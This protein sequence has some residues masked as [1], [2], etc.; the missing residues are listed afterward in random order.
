M[1][2]E[3]PLRDLD[4]I[5]LEDNVELPRGPRCTQALSLTDRTA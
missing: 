4:E 1:W 3:I 2:V 5:M